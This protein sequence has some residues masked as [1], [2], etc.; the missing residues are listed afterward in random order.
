MAF[1]RC[2][3]LKILSP[4]TC[5]ATVSLDSL[6]QMKRQPKG[7]WG[8]AAAAYL[9]ASGFPGT[10]RTADLPQAGWNRR[11]GE[12]PLPWAPECQGKSVVRQ[13]TPPESCV[14][15][16]QEGQE[17]AQQPTAGTSESET[18]TW[19]SGSQPLTMPELCPAPSLSRPFG[20]DCVQPWRACRWCL[21]LLKPWYCRCPHCCLAQQNTAQ[22]SGIHPP[23][24]F[25]LFSF[26]SFLLLPLFFNFLLCLGSCFVSSFLFL[27]LFKLTMEAFCPALL[28]TSF[29]S[30]SSPRIIY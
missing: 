28:K 12:V 29:H 9:R 19:G 11:A 15:E 24:S 8:S 26:V 16:G 13:S 7:V 3:V 1:P 20:S 27:S 14:L 30:S 21:P 17:P 18:V 10:P 6:S 25:F 23:H 2:H 22:K 4:L 5:I